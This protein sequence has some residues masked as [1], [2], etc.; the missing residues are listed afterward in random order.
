MLANLLNTTASERSQIDLEDCLSLDIYTPAKNDHN[1]CA[2]EKQ[3]P[4]MV[5]IHGGTFAS[6]NSQE[7]PANYF[8]E[9]DIVLVVPN[10]R[11]DALGKNCIMQF[12]MNNNSKSIFYFC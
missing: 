8:M 7:Y 1:F 9:K 5:Y 2:P 10:F 3:Y 4:V 11:L 6:H 12:R